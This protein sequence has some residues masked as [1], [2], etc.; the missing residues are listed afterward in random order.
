MSIEYKTCLKLRHLSNRISFQNLYLFHFESSGTQLE[1][2]IVAVSLPCML[3][4]TLHCLAHGHSVNRLL[5][6]RVVPIDPQHLQHHHLGVVCTAFLIWHQ[7]L[8]HPQTWCQLQEDWMLECPQEWMTQWNPTCPHN[9]E[10]WVVL[11]LQDMV[12]VQLVGWDSQ[13]HPLLNFSIHPWQRRVTW[14][15][16]I[17]L[18][19]NRVDR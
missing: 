10:E 17:P 15:T 4:V 9:W 16:R 1:I 8:V 12:P 7:T 14:V 19:A 6:H 3:V 11:P 13:P 18:K 2:L 5:A